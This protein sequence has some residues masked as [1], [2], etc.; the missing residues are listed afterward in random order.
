MTLLKRV[1]SISL[2][3]IARQSAG[4]SIL[5]DLRLMLSS[6][7]AATGMSLAFDTS[8]NKLLPDS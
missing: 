2:A 6:S 4:Y 1:I 5:K 7:T 3:S 8:W